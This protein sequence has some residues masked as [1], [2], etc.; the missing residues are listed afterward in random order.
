[1]KKT[2]LIFG[3]LSAAISIAMMV[4]ALPMVEAHGFAVAD[5]LG[6]SSMVLTA[7]VLFFG[8]RS[9]R[10]SAADGRMGFG[11][12]LAV[13]LAIAL[14][15]GVVYTAAF[16]LVY[17]GLRPGIGA[18]YEACMV[19]RARSSGADGAELDAAIERAETIRSLYDRPLTNAALAFAGPFS[20][21]LAAS[22]LSALVLRSRRP[23]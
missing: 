10:E 20:V 14:V 21:G 13:G 11:R 8:V 5:L 3:L 1:M 9:Y 16:Q 2:V 4:A 23:R 18:Q 17:F 15:A 12:A 22:L 7:L 19:E 6:Y